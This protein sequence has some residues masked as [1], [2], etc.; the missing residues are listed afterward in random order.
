MKF[1]YDTLL[2]DIHRRTKTDGGIYAPSPRPVRDEP[3]SDAFDWDEARSYGGLL[4]FEILSLMSG[5]LE[6][7]A[8]LT[9]RR[10][11][12][13]IRKLAGDA[14]ADERRAVELYLSVKQSLSA[15]HKPF[16]PRAPRQASRRNPVSYRWHVSPAKSY[17]WDYL[18]R[19]L[20]FDIRG[21]SA[22]WIK[23]QCARARAQAAKEARDLRAL[24]LNDEAY[25][26]DANLPKMKR[27][28]RDA[29]D[30]REFEPIRADDMDMIWPPV[31]VTVPVLEIIETDSDTEG[32][33]VEA[34]QT[35][36]IQWD[37]EMYGV[38]P[39]AWRIIMSGLARPLR[40]PQSPRASP[41]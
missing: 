1:Y 38:H 41:G 29:F 11:R 23:R 6:I 28:M 16:T 21:T 14:R 9:G 4:A 15:L 10:F 2:E 31:T 7:L 5:W 17:R 37:G 36:P 39:A 3:V 32:P 26:D 33:D 40:R 12:A 24:N 25:W 30:M 20:G 27:C 13:M 35:P 19:T 18:A 34:K 22:F 8:G